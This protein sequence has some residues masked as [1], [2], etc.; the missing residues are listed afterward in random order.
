MSNEPI[1][2]QEARTLSEDVKE[3]LR[4]PI[5]WKLGCV[6]ASFAIDLKKSLAASDVS[7]LWSLLVERSFP[8]SIPLKPLRTTRSVST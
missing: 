8:V 4:I 7:M 3:E 6:P 1:S 5:F 2:V